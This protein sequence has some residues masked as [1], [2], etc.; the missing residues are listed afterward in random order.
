MRENPTDPLLAGATNTESGNPP[1][2]L[3][4]EID[5]EAIT[6]NQEPGNMEVHHHAHHGGRKNWKSYFWEFV[7]LFLAVFCGFLAE[8][9]LEHVIEHQREKQYMQSFLYDLSNDTANLNLGFPRKDERL[10]A[11]DSVFLFFEMNPHVTKIPG[12]VYRQMQRTT[13]D[14][15]YTRNSTTIDQLRNAGGMRLIRKKIVADSIAAYDLQWQRAEYWRE[16]YIRRQET[17]REYLVNI[18]DVKELLPVFRNHKQLTSLSPAVTDS[19]T[20][21]INRTKLN[22]YLNFLFIQ[23]IT[24]GQDKQSYR[25]LERSA[26]QLI[27]V[28][29]NE[30]HLE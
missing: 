28:I 14:R 30:Y 23:K 21:S 24:T 2:E 1:E 9:Q 25:A 5:T 11:I 6:Q 3:V 10:S 15:S 19:L 27:E 29:K 7:M 13:W 16:G 20:I 4:P 18:T 22:D 12:A 17:G 26:E 8:Y